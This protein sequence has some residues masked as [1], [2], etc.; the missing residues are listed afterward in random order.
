MA[1]PAS[2]KFQKIILKLSGQALAG[3]D[4]EVF[5]PAALATVAER[6]KAAAETGIRI[7]LVCGEGT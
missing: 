1:S 6:V 2:S 7:G 4:G 3:P 5:S